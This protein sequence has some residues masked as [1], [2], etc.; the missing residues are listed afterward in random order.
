MFHVTD[1]RS[2]EFI[3]YCPPSTCSFFSAI[4]A[5][6]GVAGA[7]NSIF[8]GAGGGGQA[9]ASQQA[10]GVAQ[11]NL[12][13]LK[14][15]SGGFVSGGNQANNALLQLLGLSTGSN[16]TNGMPLLTGTIDTTAPLSQ[17]FTASTFT[18]SPGY[19]FAQQQGISAIQNSA[20]AGGGVQSGNTLRA[21]QQFGTGLENQDYYN[22][23]NLYQGQQQQLYNMLSGERNSGQN[24]LATIA[25]VT[26]GL[27]SQIGAGITG[28]ANAT[29]AG[30]VA[31][32]NGLT[33]GLQSLA[34]ILGGIG[35]GSFSGIQSLFGPS[36]YQGGGAPQTYAPSSNFFSY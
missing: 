24:A 20:A 15:N 32:S 3:E 30:Q 36:S 27:S 22:A 11:Q 2:G 19:G 13:W 16:P 21:L 18:N 4:S 25:G 14:N 26:P 9:G 17:P 6:A 31:G 12:D 1:P 7:A 5:I 34:S 29:A 33:G 10:G 28:A 35:S 8:G 23:A